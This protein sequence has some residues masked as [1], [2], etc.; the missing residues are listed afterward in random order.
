MTLRRCT[1]GKLK[2]IAIIRPILAFVF[3][4]LFGTPVSGTPSESLLLPVDGKPVAARLVA[5]TAEGEWNFEIDGK[6]AL[7]KSADFIRWGRPATTL[8]GPSLFLTDGSCLIADEA[9]AQLQIK[10]DQILFDS[11]SLGENIG[12]PLALVEGVVLKPDGNVQQ[13][14]RW[15]DKIRPE[16]RDHDVITMENGDRLTGT[17]VELGES[18]LILQTSSGD[19]LRVPRKNVRAIAFHPALL[20]KPPAA[21]RF[22]VIQLADGSSVRAVS[23]KGDAEKL[24]AVTAGNLKFAIDLNTKNDTQNLIGLLPV[25][26]TWLFLSD[27]EATAYR[28]TPYLSLKWPYQRDRNVLG[29]ILQTAGTL[30]EKGIGM[31]ADAELTYQLK[32]PFQRLDG[33]VGIDDSSMQQGS[34][35]FQVELDRG[36]STW[37]T[38]FTSRLLRGGE[39][40]EAFSLDLQNVQGIRLKVLHADGGDAMDRANWM[41]VRLIR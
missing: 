27:L 13:K 39:Q 20:E 41:L 33:S 5:C 7:F 26:F 18:E 30:Y 25:G 1:S 28:H 24:D 21:N 14:N 36:N 19:P 29:D 6:S 40:A 34:V 32:Q 15:L 12:L 8:A 31:H 9:F 38:A 17:L 11:L 3:L 4:I 37:Q 23:W 10:N 2:A 22:V 16:Q 35:I